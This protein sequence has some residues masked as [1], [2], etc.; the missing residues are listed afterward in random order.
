M[1]LCGSVA[2]PAALRAVLALGAWVAAGGKVRAGLPGRRPG[3]TAGA[4]QVYG[5]PGGCGLAHH[6]STG[7]RKMW[8]CAGTGLAG[9]APGGAWRMPA[10]PGAAGSAGGPWL[11]GTASAGFPEREPGTVCGAS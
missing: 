5:W 10:R 2:V 6:G 3:S 9:R 11:P 7:T 1:A 8:Q 4:G